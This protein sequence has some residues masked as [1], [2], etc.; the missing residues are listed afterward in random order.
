MPKKTLLLKTKSGNFEDVHLNNRLS[1]IDVITLRRLYQC[2]GAKQ[3][4]SWPFDVF[5]N[6]DK[7]NC[8]FVW[9]AGGTWS[10]I[11]ITDEG[12]GG[13]L[14][15]WLVQPNFKV[16][17]NIRSINFHGLSPFGTPRSQEGCIRFV[18]TPIIDVGYVIL[19]LFQIKLRS[20]LDIRLHTSS[21]SISLWSIQADNRFKGG[22]SF[23]AA[24]TIDVTQPFRLEFQTD[25]YISDPEARPAVIIDDLKVSY[26]PCD[27]KRIASSS[28]SNGRGQSNK[29]NGKKTWFQQVSLGQS[30]RNYFRSS[31]TSSQ[32]RSP[33]GSPSGSPLRSDSYTSE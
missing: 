18:Y 14:V 29:S 2:D 33:S 7:D 19:Q 25:Y 26:T 12:R 24:V 21:K 23:S 9:Y 31:S 32:R 28:R 30:L 8:G 27:L 13:Y 6:F 20:S 10:W 11:E 15:S 22:K 1:R 4:P 16:N 17:V 3:Q 5:C